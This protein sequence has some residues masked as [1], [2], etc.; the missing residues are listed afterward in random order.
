MGSTP[1]LG[2]NYVQLFGQV[3]EA[4]YPYSSGSTSQTGDCQYDL[5][6]VS[7][8]ATITGYNN[9]PANDQQAVMDHIANVRPKDNCPSL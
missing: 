9:L 7:P 6:S 5:S 2:Y 3:S 8:V 4:D 1:P